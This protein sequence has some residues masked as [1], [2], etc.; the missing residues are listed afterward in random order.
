MSSSIKD[1][2][3]QGF[4]STQTLDLSGHFSKIFTLT[5]DI[6]DIVS[7]VLTT[8]KRLGHFAE[9]LF[10]GLMK[11]TLKPNEQLLTNIQIVAN[12]VTLGELDIIKVAE[13]LTHIEFC[14]KVYLYDNTLSEDEFHCWIGPN[15]RDSLAQKVDKLKS[16]QLPLLF[17]EQTTSLLQKPIKNYDQLTKFQ[18]VAFMAQLYAPYSDYL[19]KKRFHYGQPDGFYIHFNALDQFQNTEWYVPA[20]KLDWI[21]HPHLNVVWMDQNALKSVLQKHYDRNSNP[22]C[23]MKDANGELFKCFVVNW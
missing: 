4:L 9:E 3:L 8:N 18:E 20:S 14:Y 22:L 11:R 15:R 19:S 5:D 7:L 1:Q 2:Y 13:Q 17:N 12:K 10:I 16:K 21:L 6:P 23:W